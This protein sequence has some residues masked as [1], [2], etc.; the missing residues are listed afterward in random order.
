MIFIVNTLLLLA[1]TV[2]FQ[3]TTGV[4]V[5]DQP[6]WVRYVYFGFVLVTGMLAIAV[7]KQEETGIFA[8][9]RKLLSPSFMVSFTRRELF[10]F[11]SDAKPRNLKTEKDI[12]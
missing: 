2:I 7:S 9:Y 4:I 8:T 12:G 3:K 1:L 5:N 11:G 6:D 10:G